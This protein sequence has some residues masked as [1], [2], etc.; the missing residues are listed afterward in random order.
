ME[1][2]DIRVLRNY[3]SIC[4]EEN[5]TRAADTLHIAQPSLSKQLMDLET[6][7]GKQLVIRGKRK[8]TMTEEGIL[9][10][11]RAEEVIELYDKMERKMK[12]DSR[13]ICGKISI[14]GAPVKEILKISAEIRNSYPDVQFDFYVN[15]SAPKG[16]EL[17]THSY[18]PSVTTLCSAPILDI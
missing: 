16:T 12:S 8:I 4:R 13:K 17:V 9:L 11:K 7:L 3:L 2:I 15:Y 14:G 10:R 18:G 1:N 5:I 6:E